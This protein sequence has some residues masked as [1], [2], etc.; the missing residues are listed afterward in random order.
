M[1]MLQME[2]EITL[3]NAFWHFKNTV[4]SKS[5]RAHYKSVIC[6]FK[7]FENINVFRWLVKCKQ[8]SVIDPLVRFCSLETKMVMSQIMLE[9]MIH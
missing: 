9:N 5:L 2:K 6:H 3:M 4:G 7:N 1:Q 8:I